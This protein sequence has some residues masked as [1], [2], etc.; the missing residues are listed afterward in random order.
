MPSL[1]EKLKLLGVKTGAKD[2]PVPPRKV[3][4]PI[5]SVIDG[6]FYKTP[7]GETFVVKTEHA[8]GSNG[9]E[10]RLNQPSSM[11]AIAA[12][13]GNADLLSLDIEDFIFIDTETSGL[14][15]GTGTYV[16]LVGIGRFIQSTFHLQQFFLRDPIEEPGYL[17]ALLSSFG[18]SKGLVTFNGKSFDVPLLRTRFIINNE[19]SP[20]EGMIHI[21][22]LPLARRLWRDRLPSRTLGS[23][24]QMILGTNRT[25][26]DIPG[27]LIPGLYFDFLRDGD[28]RPLKN[29]FYHNSM[30]VVSMALLLNH[31]VE[32][33][34]DPFN[35]LVEDGID[36]IA[37]AKFFEDLNETDSAA[38]YYAHGL[39]KNI[40]D[41]IRT[42]ALY[43][44]SYMEK[45]RQNFDIATQIWKEATHHNEIYAFIELAKYYEHHLRDINE[46]LQWTQMAISMLNTSGI[47]ATD[48]IAMLEA[49]QHRLTRLERK[50]GTQE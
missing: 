19:V 10:F 44:W 21:D 12:W 49:L 46:A 16:F 17:I 24:E 34:K 47:R 23:L 18:T 32:I 22:L 37:I 26:E 38:S 31:I 36:W 4:Y 14:A 33:L 25:E 15:G 6:I 11:H 40:P 13:L 43:R 48:T 9:E 8:L 30:Y 39:S 3:S 27:Y 28:A 41:H 7:V 42:E 45:R 1:S 29:V 2:L 35:G 50:S 5:E 20:F